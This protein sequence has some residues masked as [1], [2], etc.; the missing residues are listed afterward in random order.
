MCAFAIC[1]IN[2][3]Q[4]LSV[5]LCMSHEIF[6]CINTFGEIMVGVFTNFFSFFP[7][8]AII[9]QYVDTCQNGAIAL[10]AEIGR[11][12]LHGVTAWM[13]EIFD[14]VIHFIFFRIKGI[15]DN[16]FHQYVSVFLK[17]FN[18]LYPFTFLF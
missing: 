13:C 11:N 18:S 12:K 1:K 3:L 10:S 4:N 9:R 14:Q 16:I 6:M 7:S 17:I 5:L 2:L 15:S 8:N